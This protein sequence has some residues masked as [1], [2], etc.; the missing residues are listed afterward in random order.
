MATRKKR[1]R[2]PV[3]ANPKHCVFIT[4]RK[5]ELEIDDDL[6]EHAKKRGGKRAA[7]G[8]TIPQMTRDMRYEFPSQKQSINFYRAV[9]RYLELR[10]GFPKKRLI[11]LVQGSNV[12]VV[13]VK[14]R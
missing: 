9:K 3:F 4:Y 12:S 2:Y 7:S 10:K 14:K 5:C 1:K 13:K 11:V 8:C 6:D